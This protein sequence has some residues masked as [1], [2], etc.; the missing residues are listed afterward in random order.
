MAESRIDVALTNAI[1][2]VNKSILVV[3]IPP[4]G[5]PRANAET[6]IPGVGNC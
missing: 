3:T 1:L 4:P 5:N 6:L 2:V